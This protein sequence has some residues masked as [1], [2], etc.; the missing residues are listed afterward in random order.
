M[1]AFLGGTVQAG[2]ARPKQDDPFET[3]GVRRRS[4]SVRSLPSV[5][6][7]MQFASLVLV[8]GSSVMSGVRFAHARM[9]AR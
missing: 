4:R 9:S 2:L 6:V 1:H 7:A 5:F 3:A 8:S